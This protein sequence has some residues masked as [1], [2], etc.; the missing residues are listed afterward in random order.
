MRCRKVMLLGGMVLALAAWS[1]ASPSPQVPE[2][3][4]RSPL[5]ATRTPLTIELYCYNGLAYCE[6]YASGG[7]GGGYSFTWTNALERYDAD[8]YSW[9]GVPCG[10]T[11]RVTATVTD[12]S[13]AT[14]GKSTY[15]ICSGG[16]GS[17][18]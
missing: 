14:A 3:A 15:Y 13:G 1:D 5:S 17:T 9:A 7:T 18:S 10:Y 4:M 16:G 6:A 8:G 11:I 2:A 12:S